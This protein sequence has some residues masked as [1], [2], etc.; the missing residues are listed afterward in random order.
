MLKNFYL[1]LLTIPIFLACDVL[2]LGFVARDF[3]RQQLGYLMRPEANWTAA[4]IFYLVFIAGLLTFGILPAL[5]KDSFAYAV[6]YGGLFGFFCYA[7]FDLT[8]LAVLRDFPLKMALAD[9][10]WGIVLSG[11]VSAA[12]FFIGRKLIF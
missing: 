4:L 11:V 6:I 5:E 12:S 7:T 10:L 8:G 1:Y 9:M 2:W 3:Y